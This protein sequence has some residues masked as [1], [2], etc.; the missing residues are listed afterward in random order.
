MPMFTVVPSVVIDQTCKLASAASI[1]AVLARF[2][3]I[4]LQKCSIEYAI[5]IF[6]RIFYVIF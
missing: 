2:A 5:E 4:P 3:C 6:D 1:K